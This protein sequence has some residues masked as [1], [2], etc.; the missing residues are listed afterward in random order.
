MFGDTTLD[1]REIL[2]TV[3]QLGGFAPAAQKLN[4]SQSTINYAIGRL[5]LQL[6]VRLFAI[7]GKDVQLTELGSVV[8]AG[9]EPHLAGFEALIPFADSHFRTVADR[10]PMHSDSQQWLNV[11]FQAIT[12]VQSPSGTPN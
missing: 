7:Q 3:V 9:A 1:A 5:Q 11:V 12:R 6:G 2:Q 8:L 4:R 10:V